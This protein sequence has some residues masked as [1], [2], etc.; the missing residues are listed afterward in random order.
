MSNDPRHQQLIA[1]GWRY[2]AAQNRYTP[3]GEVQ[4]GT[5]K[6]YN[7]E[8]AWQAYQFNQVSDASPRPSAHR[9]DKRMQ[10]PE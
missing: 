10:E 8:A 3:P 6:W 7:Q 1:A 5:E 9:R 2:D 4:P